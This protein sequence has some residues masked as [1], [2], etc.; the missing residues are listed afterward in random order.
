MAIEIIQVPHDAD[1]VRSHVDRYKAFRL[2]S[3]QTS[4]EAFGSTYARE[5]AFT[6]DVWYSRLADP[7][8]TTFFALESGR[9]VGTLT[10]IGPLPSSPEEMTPSA[11]P[12]EIVGRRDQPQLHYR[13]RSTGPGSC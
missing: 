13:I 1:S 2:L 11:N 9:I 10:T 3:L 12:W 6:D 7:I 8:A 5:V 4:P